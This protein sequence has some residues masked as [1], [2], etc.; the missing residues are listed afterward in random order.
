MAPLQKRAKQISNHSKNAAAD[1]HGCLF[2]T[3]NEK[4]SR[5]CL[6]RLRRR[7]PGE[8]KGKELLRNAG[9]F[10]MQVDFAPAGACR[11]GGG[12]RQSQQWPD[13]IARLYRLFY[14]SC[15][16]NRLAGVEIVCY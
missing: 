16:K 15:F 9:E 1:A 14:R 11:R 5:D 4:V 3:K 2:G 7:T 8:I 13:L 6:K 10:R 12:V